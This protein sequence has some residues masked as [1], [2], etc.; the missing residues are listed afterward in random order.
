MKRTFT[1]NQDPGPAKPQIKQSGDSLY[2]TQTA[3]HYQWF[4]DSVA[5]AD[6]SLKSIKI[7]LGGNYSVRIKNDRSCTASSDYFNAQA[8]LA[9]AT[10]DLNLSF[11][12]V[13]F[14]PNPAINDIN[15]SI[16]VNQPAITSIT[17]FDFQG[18]IIQSKNLGTVYSQ[19]TENIN[20]SSYP[21]GTYL[22]RASANDEI[23][24]RR[25]VKH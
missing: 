22:I 13:E 11:Q 12:Q 1:V 10:R 25:F 15:V 24:T 20:V 5:I 21:S 23:V 7:Q 2:V 9:A 17:I 19:V 4:K 8:P 3:T 18:R 6:G 16:A 14:Y